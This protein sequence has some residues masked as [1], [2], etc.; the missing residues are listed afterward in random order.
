MGAPR[1]GHCDLRQPTRA[2]PRRSVVGRW[3]PSSHWGFCGLTTVVARGPVLDGQASNSRII[4]E[5]QPDRHCLAGPM[6]PRSA[7]VGRPSQEDAVAVRVVKLWEAA[8]VIR[9]L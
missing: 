9:R 5:W 3:S 2:T 8:G 4:C 7:I 1:S 6:L